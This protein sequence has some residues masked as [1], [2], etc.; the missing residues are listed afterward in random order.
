MLDWQVQV[1]KWWGHAWGTHP[2][3]HVTVMQTLVPVASAVRAVIMDSPLRLTL[4]TRPQRQ[5]FADRWKHA[6]HDEL[7]D[8]DG[9]EF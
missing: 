9:Q 8:E 2:R 6:E 3:K 5:F 1:T 4:P 7:T